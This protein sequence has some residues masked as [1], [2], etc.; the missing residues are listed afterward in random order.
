MT[1][2]LSFGK[3]LI[4][5]DEQMTTISLA[6]LHSMILLPDQALCQQQTILRNV[7]NIDVRKYQELKKALPYFVCGKFA[8][9][10][11]L[12][13]EF[14][15]TSGFVLDLDN[16]E[17]PEVTLEELKSRL[18]ADQ[19]IAL[20][21][22]SPSGTGLKM[23]FL[24]D[25]PCTDANVYASFYRQFAVDFARQYDIERFVDYK[26]NDVTR[27]CFLAADSDCHFNPD[28]EPVCIAKYVDLQN[29]DVFFSDN[30]SLTVTCTDLT[31]RKVETKEQESEPCNDTMQRIKAI[32]DTNRRK[33][34]E[35]DDS[36]AFVP[37]A[38]R[39]VIEGLKASV[40]A[41]GVELYE[42][43]GIQFGVKLMFRSAMFTAE[44]NLF[45]GKKGF[46][47]VLSPKKGTSA[48]LGSL[49]AEFVSDYIYGIT[50]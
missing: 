20:M 40:E 47:V 3:H 7:R 18:S 35:K 22:I 5:Q 43:K 17:N 23:L 21:F 46:S 11:R 32:L 49:M 10:R 26:T 28:S 34:A 12:A 31:A 13:D 48:Q 2:E 25:K 9:G 30:K 42:T 8:S 14:S 16:Y 6:D 24:L 41:T 36:M 45:Y 37:Q 33:R 39:S 29:V 44:I 38:V 50:A 27:A 15:S 19:R 1:M 4:S